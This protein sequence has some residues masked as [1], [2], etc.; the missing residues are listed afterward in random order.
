VLALLLV[1][2]IG[3]IV[4]WFKVLY[5]EGAQ[6]RYLTPVSTDAPGQSFESPE[7]APVDAVCGFEMSCGTVEEHIQ[8]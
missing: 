5:S 1:W 6:R 3:L 7:G 8:T 4:L 2:A